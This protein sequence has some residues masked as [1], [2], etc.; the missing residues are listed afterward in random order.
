M[1]TVVIFYKGDELDNTTKSLIANTMV[2]AGIN[3][4][5]IDMITLNDTE[6]A[7]LAG[8]EGARLIKEDSEKESEK[9]KHAY[10]YISGLF[11]MD[12]NKVTPTIDIITNFLAIC[13]KRLEEGDEK[14]KT[15]LQII[16]SADIKHYYRKIP[17]QIMSAIEK[18][19]DLNL[20]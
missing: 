7:Q 10:N 8:F 2:K 19:H 4:D 18:L 15:A 1:R 20:I 13:I 5:T 14:L 17:S 11:G 16:Y 12:L 9:Y 3:V 6:T